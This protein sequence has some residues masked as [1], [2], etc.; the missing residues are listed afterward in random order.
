MGTVILCHQNFVVLHYSMYRLRL[1]MDFFSALTGFSPSTPVFSPL[2][3]KH[4]ETFPYSKVSPI[5]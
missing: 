4:Q 3:T 1:L 2:L 5:I